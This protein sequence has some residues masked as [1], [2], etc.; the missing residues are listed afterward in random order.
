MTALLKGCTLQGLKMLIYYFVN[1]AFSPFCA[2]Q[3]ASLVLP[4]LAT[5]SNSLIGKS[6]LKRT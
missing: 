2:L 4:A 6:V 5:F 3:A 1:S